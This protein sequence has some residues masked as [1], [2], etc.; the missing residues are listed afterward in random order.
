MLIK[1]KLLFLIKIK[2]VWKKYNNKKLY[3]FN[4]I[5]NNFSKVI[6]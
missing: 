3:Y 6:Y 5:L 2:Y 4:L 1:N